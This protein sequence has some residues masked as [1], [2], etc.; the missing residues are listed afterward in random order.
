MGTKET[1]ILLNASTRS[2]L[3]YERER[4]GWTLSH[5]ATLIDCPDPHM[6]ARWERG[7]ITPSP[8]Y[9]QVLCELFGKDAEALGFIAKERRKKEAHNGDHV[10][11][12]TEEKY[13]VSRPFPSFLFNERL[14]HS[15]EFYGRRIEREILL[16]RTFHGSSTS[17]VGPR[18]IGKTWLLE[19]LLLEAKTQLGSCFRVGYLDATLASCATVATFTAKAAKQLGVVLEPERA[20]LGLVALEEVVETLKG[21][22][23]HAILCIDEFEGLIG[24]PGFDV[25]FFAALRAMAQIDLCLVT[26]SRRPLIDILGNKRNTSG[27]FNIFEQI[28]VEPF[29][30][31][32]AETFVIGKSARVG[33][34]EHE[35]ELL[36][37]YGQSAD[38]QWPPIRLQLAGKMH[39]E[40]KCA[41][42]RSHPEYMRYWQRFAQQLEEKYQRVVC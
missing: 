24:K 27:F 33:F 15:D 17:L 8:R 35:Q 25:H 6:V 30:R 2:E 21:E 16:N 40:A 26:A 41:V 11:H 42:P 28:T 14:P 32:D 4:R 38:G 18:R 22:G 9:R 19:Y 12:Q 10:L 13:A 5:V 31:E 36:L 1:N 34:H 37:R 39:L 20:V 3:K 23:Y 29:A 7:S